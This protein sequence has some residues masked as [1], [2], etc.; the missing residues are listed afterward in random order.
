MSSVFPLLAAAVLSAPSP[1]ARLA[2]LLD[3]ARQNNPEL[4]A[5]QETAASAEHAVSP[6][7]ALDDP[8]LMLQLWNVPVDFS[9]VPVMATLTQPIPLGGKRAA[10]RGEAS[11]MA[12]EARASA[13]MKAREVEEAVGRAYFDLFLADRTLEVDA[14]IEATLHSLMVS[15]SSRIA[16]G[17]G[18]QAEALRAQGEMLTVQ[19]DRE[20]A[21][22]RRTAASSK[23]V[24]LLARPPG[25]VLGPTTEPG[26]LDGLASEEELRAR[27]LEQ[28][29]ELA[30]ARAGIARAEAAL[31]MAEADKVPDLSV[32]VGE[33]HMFRGMGVSDFLFLG[34]Q[35][36]LPIWSGSKTN[37]KMEAARAAIRARQ[38]ELRAA[39]NRIVAEVADVYG[40]LTAERHQV[41]LHHQLIPVA[42]QALSSATSSYASDRGDFLMVIDSERDLLMHELDSAQHQA[43]YEQRLAELQ[44]AVG[45]EIGLARASESG[46]RVR[47]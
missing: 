1:V 2:D 33:M 42:R 25:S 21:Q 28:R 15:A 29:P 9:T 24:A 13:E 8:M 6:A 12:A 41:E 19:S 36:N 38:A 4:K 37:P 39:E 20:Q 47:H 32:S 11:A 45:A 17:K 27:A 44:R 35:G 31:R 40:E 5:A 14:E 10:R 46:T 30:M 34:V 18:E 7:G 3:E 23:L 16:A 26:L 43:M 22:A